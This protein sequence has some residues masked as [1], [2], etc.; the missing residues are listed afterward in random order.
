MA[1]IKDYYTIKLHDTDA[2]GVLF[3]A[4][5]F[6]IVHDLY[7]QFLARIGSTFRER[8]IAGDFIIPIVHAEADFLQPLSVGDTIEITASVAK[9]GNSSFALEYQLIDLDGWVMGTASTVHVTCDPRTH[10][11]INLP[12][13][14]RRRIEEFMEEPES[15]N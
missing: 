4:H 5:Q 9:I 12:E 10:E 14:L 7:E 2:A 11:K 15:E 6:R 8:I 3:F 1:I 13:S